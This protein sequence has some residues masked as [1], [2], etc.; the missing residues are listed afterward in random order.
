MIYEN[1]IA[2]FNELSAKDPETLTEDEIFNLEFLVEKL[3]DWATDIEYDY[4]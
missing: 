2:R 1:V 4:D 3:R